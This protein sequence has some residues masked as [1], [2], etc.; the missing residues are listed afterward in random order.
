ME[1]VL[2]VIFNTIVHE[3]FMKTKALLFKRVI[4]SIRKTVELICES[5]CKN[6]TFSLT[7]IFL[8]VHMRVCETS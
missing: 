6:V 5:S 3:N 2:G 7:L 8:R 1:K 4:L